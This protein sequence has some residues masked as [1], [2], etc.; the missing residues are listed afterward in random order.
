[1][2]LTYIYIGLGGIVIGLIFSIVLNVYS[3]AAASS[4]TYSFFGMDIMNFITQSTFFGLGLCIAILA[5]CS[6]LVRDLKY[7]RA[8]PIK[9]TIETLLMGTLCASIIFV[10]TVFRGYTIDSSTW[11]EFTALFVKFGLLHILLQ[12][13]GVYSELFPYKIR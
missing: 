3:K 8:D 2:D 7:P 9:F 12:F 10:M 1:M 4:L 11:I 13:S 6:V 5:G